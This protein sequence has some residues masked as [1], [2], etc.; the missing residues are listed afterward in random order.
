MTAAQRKVIVLGTVTRAGVED[1][2]RFRVNRFATD[3]DSRTREGGSAAASRCAQNSRDYGG[4]HEVM[5][6]DTASA[7]H[8]ALKGHTFRAPRSVP[9]GTP[10]I[11]R[12]V[13]GLRSW[14]ARGCELDNQ[15]SDGR[16]TDPEDFVC[17]VPRRGEVGSKVSST[18]VQGQW[19][20]ESRAI[21]KLYCEPISCSH[22]A[23]ELRPSRV[24]RAVSDQPVPAAD[25]ASGGPA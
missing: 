20:F 19:L 25:R 16:A 12:E 18:P 10:M 17:P 2:Y 1:Y 15:I 23:R 14:K 9:V 4:V 5:L 11:L 13:K 8:C 22:Y 21:S 3:E 24:R 6:S 7:R